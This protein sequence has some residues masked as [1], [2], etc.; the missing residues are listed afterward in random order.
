VILLVLIYP[1][2]IHIIHQPTLGTL[3]LGV[4]VMTSLYGLSTAPA[5]VCLAEGFPR[6]RRSTS[7]ALT[8][9]I[10]VSVFGGSAQFCIA[11]LI[12]STGSPMVPG[13][14]LLGA[15]AAGVLAGLA[16]PVLPRRSASA[17][18][19]AVVRDRG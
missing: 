10:A 3:S 12:K 15:T 14:W 8:Y 19:L 5:N 6:A 11:W 9:T 18:A 2:L 16:M 1:L 13:W 4:F 7:Y 17:A